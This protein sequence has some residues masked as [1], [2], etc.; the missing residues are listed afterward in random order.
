MQHGSNE[1]FKPANRTLPLALAL[2][3]T[4]P[5]GGGNGSAEG[6]NAT[7]GLFRGAFDNDEDCGEDK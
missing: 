5:D 6:S 7:S 2:T 1:G 4:H 3:L